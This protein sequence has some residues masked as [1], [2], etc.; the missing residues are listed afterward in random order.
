MRFWGPRS[1]P[2]LP[3]VPL[4]FATILVFN[5][6]L[7]PSLFTSWETEAGPLVKALGRGLVRAS[8]LRTE[9]PWADSDLRE[10]GA[11]RPH[12]G[13][14]TLVHGRVLGGSG[15]WGAGM[16]RRCWCPW[17]PSGSGRTEPQALGDSPLGE[18]GRHQS[19]RWSPLPPSPSRVQR[20]PR[21]GSGQNC[22]PRPPATGSAPA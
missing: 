15:F 17:G 3:R 1:L 16:P 7:R 19:P 10:A 22:C 14:L 6:T 8:V 4:L 21:G 12:S 13:A 20:C 2:G 9:R 11:L 18:E 5:V